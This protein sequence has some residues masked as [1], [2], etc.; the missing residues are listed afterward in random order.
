MKTLFLSLT[1]ALVLSTD[2]TAFGQP[3]TSDVSSASGA[4]S[5]V[6]FSEIR[7]RS[8]QQSMT[9][10]GVWA[11]V[12]ILSG[13]ALSV[14]NSN[15]ELKYLGYQNAGWGAVNGAITVFALLGIA[16]D[17]SM[18]GTAGGSVQAALFKEIGEEQSFSKILLVN[19]GLDVGYMLAGGVLMY[20][21]R[22]G[23]RDGEKFYGSGAG[24]LIQGAFLLA[25]DVV[26]IV[27]SSQRLDA[28]Q[29]TL[30]PMLGTLGAG[31]PNALLSNTAVTGLTLTLRF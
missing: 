24:I 22:N 6:R 19:A 31:F 17:L 29:M 15:T 28:V 13:I 23:L 21:A 16:R 11:G 27:W 5:A 14:Q 18:L 9:V 10:L 7:L 4:S 25:F 8:Q 2:E 3:T 12:S 26:Q 30:S 20:A 1:L